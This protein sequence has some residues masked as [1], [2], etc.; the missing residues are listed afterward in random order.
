MLRANDVAAATGF[1]HSAAR[2]R[3]FSG[4]FTAEQYFAIEGF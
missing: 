3:D 4:R 2:V 1:W